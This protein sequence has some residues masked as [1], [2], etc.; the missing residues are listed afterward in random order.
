MEIAAQQIS[1][2]ELHAVILSATGKPALSDRSA[3]AAATL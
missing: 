1:S 2:A 3:S